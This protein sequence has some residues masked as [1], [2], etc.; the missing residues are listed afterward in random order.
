MVERLNFSL[1]KCMTRIVKNTCPFRQPFEKLESTQSQS[2]STNLTQKSV[3]PK[4][5]PR[6]LCYFIL[7]IDY[8]VKTIESAAAVAAES[9]RSPSAGSGSNEQLF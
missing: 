8:D 1:A 6:C 9:V 7:V 5:L 2:S 4:N 3:K